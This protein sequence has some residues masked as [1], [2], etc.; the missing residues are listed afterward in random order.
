MESSGKTFDPAGPT[1]DIVIK[2]AKNDDLYVVWKIR[3]QEVTFATGE[4]EK[5]EALLRPVQEETN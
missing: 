5:A 1:T 4:P 2:A 3:T